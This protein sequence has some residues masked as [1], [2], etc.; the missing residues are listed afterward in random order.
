MGAEILGEQAGRQANGPSV[1]V[2]PQ[3]GAG[4]SDV[5]ALE[6]A[7]GLVMLIAGGMTLLGRRRQSDV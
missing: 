1:M 3:T 4:D 5:L 7:A 2:L 6:T